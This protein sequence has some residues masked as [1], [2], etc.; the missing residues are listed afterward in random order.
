[1]NTLLNKY[2]KSL[3]FESQVIDFENAYTSHPNYPSL[4]AITDSLNKLEIENIAANVPLKHIEQLPLKFITVLNIES[5]DYYIISRKNDNVVIEDNNGIIK[6][7][8]LAE[9]EKYWTGII[10]II[11]ENNNFLQRNT[12]KKS[13]YLITF[14]LLFLSMLSIITF[15]LNVIQIIFMIL[16]GIGVF[17]SIEILKTYFNDTNS[18][19][20]K[21]CT[22]NE[23]FSCKSIINSKSYSFSKY[24]EFVDLP[25]LFFSIT[26]ISQILGFD[27]LIYIGILCLISFPFLVYSI[28]LQKIVLKKWCFLCLIVSIL[29]T[30]MTLLYLLNYKSLN[31]DYQHLVSLLILSSL[32]VI[33]WFLLK[34]QLKSSRE[35]TQNINTL[36]RFKRNEDV[37]YKMAIPIEDKQY[38]DGIYKINIGNINA[39]NTITLFL[40]P[41]CPHCHTVYKKTIEFVAKYKEQ[42]KLEVCFNININNLENPYLDVVKTIL[43]L[44]NTNKDCKQALDDWHIKNIKLE[45]WLTKW[46]ET[47][48]F[49][50]E[51]NQIENQYQWCLNNNLNYAPIKI[52]NGR[53]LPEIYE[54]NEMFYFFEE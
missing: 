27:V 37:F 30:C 23:N 3:N 6:T 8:T 25:I 11:E 22:A 21:L 45:E 52:F 2:L 18:V 35:N 17:V 20:S 14:L 12:F 49:T 10:L 32:I 46:K 54:I 38:F 19:E 4:L 42:V 50:T 43:H 51:N 48:S 31:P 16:T 41:S 7:F 29:L 5:N 44:Y 26:F 40:S 53:L 1:M 9:L 39:K 47:D 15:E 24:L 34:K 36:L 13:N 28:Y 33:A